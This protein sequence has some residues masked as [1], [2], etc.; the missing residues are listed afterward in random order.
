MSEVSTVFSGM[1]DLRALRVSRPAS[2]LCI[3]HRYPKVVG[4][5]ILD[6]DILK[7]MILHI[8]LMFHKSNEIYDKTLEGESYQSLTNSFA[9]SRSI[10]EPQKRQLPLKTARPLS[11]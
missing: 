1:R 4:L 11:A 6:L 3:Q 7:A 2:K 5:D 10:A 8:G 9:I